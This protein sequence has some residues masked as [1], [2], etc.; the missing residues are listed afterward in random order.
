MSAFSF[1]PVAAS[2][3]AART[4]GIFLLLIALSGVIIA[5]VLC[6]VITFAIRYRRGS[7]APRGEMPKLMSRQFEIGWTA[8]TVF[9]AFFVFW[10]TASSQLSEFIPPANALEI[11]VV[12][13]QWMW[14]TQHAEGAREIDALHVPIATPVKLIMTSQDV[15]HSF[16]VPAMR[17]KQDVV[18]GRYTQTWF[19]ATKLG[20]FHILC[21]E[22]CGTRHSAMAGEVVVM[23]QEDYG[24]WLAA[25]PHADD[26]AHEGAVLFRAN[27]CSGCHS[28]TSSVHAPDL[29]GIIGRTVPLADGRKATVDD[30]YLHDAM[31]LPKRDV[32]A[33]YTPIM[34][35]Y[36]G[37]LSEGDIGSIIAYLRSPAFEKDYPP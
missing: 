22:F 21:A 33:G 3:Q 6:L 29:R 26:L 19:T 4:D 24:G 13:K 8:A 14:K 2:T 1:M 30:S 32:A 37:I 23:T 5:I 12:A 7:K 35:N 9:V 28:P 15:I 10:W 31:V 16:F 25:Q 11:H 27:G 20:T 18:P 36:A 17:M 34:P